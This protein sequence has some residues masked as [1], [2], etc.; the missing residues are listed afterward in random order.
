MYNRRDVH[1]IYGTLSIRERICISV[2]GC[3]L[4]SSELAT[5]GW[6]EE[7]ADWC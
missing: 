5:R 4:E 2:S 1:I 3:P 7:F 6:F